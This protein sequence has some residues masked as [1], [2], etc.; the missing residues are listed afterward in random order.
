MLYFLFGYLDKLMDFPGAGLFNFISFR[1][2]MAVITSL[3][4]SMVFGGRLIKYLKRR[5]IGETIRELGLEG[6][7]EK[8]GTPTMGGLI[9]LGATLLPVLLFANLSNIYIQLLLFTT[10]WLGMIGFI[11]DYIKVFKKNK[12]GLSGR[13]KIFGQVILGLVVG[14][15]MYFSPDIVIRE[16]SRT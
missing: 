14:V 9:I 15:T 12:E 6:Q 5:Q 1:A 10:I 16:K 4:I 11:D 3:T 8:A 2:A 7:K 13:F